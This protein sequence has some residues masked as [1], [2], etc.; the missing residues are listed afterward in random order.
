MSVFIPPDAPDKRYAL[1]GSGG[2]AILANEA[3]VPLL[4]ELPLE[5]PVREGGDAGSPVVLSHPESIS[6]Q[7]FLALA[8]QLTAAH[9]VPA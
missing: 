8:H 6:A 9:L 7:A 4:A 3:G 1:F 2:G 5:M